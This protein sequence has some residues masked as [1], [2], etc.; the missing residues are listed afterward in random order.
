MSESHKKSPIVTK[1]ENLSKPKSFLDEPMTR[2]DF[3]RGALAV[4]GG[5]V[6]SKGLEM[7]VKDYQEFQKE[8]N[9]QYSESLLVQAAIELMDNLNL[10]L[11]KDQLYGFVYPTTRE[12]AMK[13]REAFN[14]KVGDLQIPSVVTVQEKD[15]K[16]LIGSIVHLKR[17]ETVPRVQKSNSINEPSIL[18]LPSRMERQTLVHSIT[19][20]YHEGLHLFFQ[21]GKYDLSSPDNVFLHE[22]MPSIADALLRAPLL[23]IDP[24]EDF[25]ESVEAIY[26]EAVAKNDRSIWETFL[27]KLYELPEDCCVTVPTK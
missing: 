2:R 23:A 27:K 20:L 13:Y 6:I 17:G 8:E 10:E 15:P 18:R 11:P 16:T 21:S 25:D 24:S 5:F 19:D 4:A 22:N 26:K 7:G 9:S 12:M 1:G 14:R 3:M